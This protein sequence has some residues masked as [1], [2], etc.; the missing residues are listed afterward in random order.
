MMEIVLARA[1]ANAQA[2][3][4]LA[5]GETAPAQVAEAAAV[6]AASGDN[7]EAEKKEEKKEEEDT[8]AGLGALFG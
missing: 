8:A 4:S 5:R 7:Q 1:A 3:A 2:I 6:S